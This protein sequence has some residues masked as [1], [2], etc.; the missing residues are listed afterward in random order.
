MTFAH[1][2]LPGIDRDRLVAAV[3]PILVAHGVEGVELLWHTDRGARVLKV[4]LECP[5][6]R[7]PG[8]GITVDLCSEISRELSAALDVTDVVPG[9]YRLEVGSPGLERALYTTADYARFA[10][11]L[12]RLKLREAVDGEHVLRGTLHGL[13]AES[14][15]L[16]ATPRGEVGIDLALIDH[17]RL[18]FDWRSSADSSAASPSRSGRRATRG[19]QHAPR[20]QRSR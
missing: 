10:G 17:A 8:Q 1:E 14:R 4:T 7:I 15:V 3:E 5:G 20:P 16:I 18:V 2:K 6:S 13:D 12:A 11:Q 19:G 9:H